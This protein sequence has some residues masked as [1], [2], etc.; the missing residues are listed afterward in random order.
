MAALNG[1]QHRPG[2]RAPG[3]EVP[4]EQS[5]PGAGRSQAGGV[6]SRAAAGSISSTPRTPTPRATC[7]KCHSL[8]RVISQR[9]TRE[10][11]GPADRDASRL[12][13]ARRQP[14]V[15]PRRARRRAI[16]RADGRPPDTRH[17]VEKA[18][19][20]LAQDVPAE[21]AGVGGVVGDDAAGAPRRHVGAER[22]GAGQGRDLRP[23]RRSPP[24]PAS[25]DEFTTDDDLSRTRAPARRSRAPAAPSSTP[26]SSGAADRRRRRTDSALREVM[27]VDRDWRDDGGP[28]VHRRLRRARPRRE[29][30]ARR[31]RDARARHRPHGAAA[32][33][34]G[35]ELKIYGAN[36]PASLR[37]RRHRSRP[38]HHRDARSSA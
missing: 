4:V 16:R 21:D 23:R 38:R 13:S 32:G 9:R 34:T 22:M 2:D 35:Q 33:A 10:R 14:G 15:P 12:V 30:R 20:H 25:P 5:R 24:I 1:L 11:V 8:G 31:R 3:R 19:D 7:N 29:A 27:F 6:G 36:L 26:A 18:V 28:L 17:P 37:P